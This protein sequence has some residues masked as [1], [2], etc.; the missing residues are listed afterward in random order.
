MQSNTIC[1]YAKAYDKYYPTALEEARVQFKQACEEG[2]NII[3]DRTNAYPESRKYWVVNVPFDYNKIAVVFSVSIEEV[4]LR[5]H[6]RRANII[7]KEDVLKKMAEFVLPT[8]EEGFNEVLK[9]EDLLAVLPDYE[10]RDA[11]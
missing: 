2:N 7:S 11:A 1:L 6:K 4:E 8:L 5:M 10:E 3:I 9:A